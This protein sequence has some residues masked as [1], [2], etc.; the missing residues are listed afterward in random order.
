MTLRDCY[1]ESWQFDS[2]LPKRKTEIL[3]ELKNAAPDDHYFAYMVERLISHYDVPTTLDLYKKYLTSATSRYGYRRSHELTKV[4]LVADPVQVRQMLIT[5]KMPEFHK[6]IFLFKDL[7][8]DEEELG[9]RAL[10]KSKFCPSF[11]FEA[12]YKPTLEA[13]KRL[14]SIMRL[15]C[16]ESLCSARIASY[17][18]FENIKDGE[19]FK[20]LLFSSALK[21]R[22]QAESIWNKYINISAVGF[23]ST[24]S[25]AGC[26]PKCGEFEFTFN[27][28]V[29]RTAEALSVSRIGW[30][31]GTENCPICYTGLKEALK[32]TEGEWKR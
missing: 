5:S 23:P 11:V 15:H 6:Q 1:N 24:V 27:N 19:E 21:H 12:N 2:L 26:C 30:V 16:L 9:L 3:D 13:L 8:V 10:S 29:F 28:K 14:P 7:T 25:A 18:V 31:F 22:D 4:A 20:T 32:V 17:N